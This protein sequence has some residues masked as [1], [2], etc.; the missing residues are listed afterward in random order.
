MTFFSR[1][2]SSIFL[3]LLACAVAVVQADTGQ[4][5]DDDF[6]RNLVATRYVEPFRTGD[7][8][9]WIQAF[10]EDAIALHNHRPADRG[11]AA[12]EQFGREVHDNLILAEY[13]V[14]VTDIRRSDQWVYTAGVY[15]SRFVSKLD[16]SE[17][18]GPTQGKFVL[19]WELQD[20]GQWR[21]ILDMGNTSQR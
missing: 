10:D 15:S 20:D 4:V 3:C 11:R 1:I 5:P 12:I 16:G 21:I 18:F 8:E 9:G 7:V 13:D 14:K 17:P 6:F 2:Q 19:L